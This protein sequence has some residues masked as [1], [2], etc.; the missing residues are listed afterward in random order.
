M[1]SGEEEERRYGLEQKVSANMRG[2]RTSGM[3]TKF[4]WFVFAALIIA[5]VACNHSST[6]ATAN[7][8]TVAPANPA[9]SAVSVP[10]PSSA[11]VANVAAAPQAGHASSSSGFSGQ[12][13]YDFVA[14]QVAFGPRPPDTDAIRKTQAYIIGVLRGFGCTV[15]TDDFHAQT[16]VGR[17]AMKNIIVKIKGASPNIIVLATHYDTD[18]LDPNDR[19]IANFVGADDA[20]SSTGLMMEM[21]HVLCGK[22]QADTIWIAILDG[23]E[24]LKHWDLQTDAVFGSRELAASMA[25][26]GELSRVKA[27][28]LADMVGG[29]SFHA[30]RNTDAAPWLEN[31]VWN[32][33]AR[34][35]H[36]DMFVNSHMDGIQDDHSPWLE[37]GIPTLDIISFDVTHD[38]PYWHTPQDTMDKISPRTLQ[39]VGDVILASLPE[40]ARH[41][42]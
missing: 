22:P 14:K 2:N 38:V 27:F 21:A 9:A 20:G 42:R 35:G 25:V 8:T 30:Q 3:R 28:V 26:S 29:K 19:K 1:G 6:V 41:S 40:I 16:P 10:A 23:E 34:L 4:I 5:V 7:T 13:A 15:D 11:D 32:T 36:S 31:I 37:R 33:A 18:T 12:E 17:L 39:V 24:A